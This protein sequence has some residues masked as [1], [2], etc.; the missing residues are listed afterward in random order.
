MVQK[1]D[2]QIDVARGIAIL[3]VL[4]GHS[5]YTLDDPINKIILAFHMP[6]FF[7]LSGLVAKPANMI[8]TTGGG[9]HTEKD[10]GNPYTATIFRCII[11]YLLCTVHCLCERRKLETG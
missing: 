3:L 1:R 5:S 7:F 9:V 6:L 8:N 4:L 2:A 11:I 10:K